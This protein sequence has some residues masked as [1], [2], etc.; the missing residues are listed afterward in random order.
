[1][2]RFRPGAQVVGWSKDALAEFV[3]ASE[4]ALGGP[5][6]RLAVRALGWWGVDVEEIAGVVGEALPGLAVEVAGDVDTGRF[7]F[8][9]VVGMGRGRGDADLGQELLHPPDRLE[10]GWW[11]LMASTTSSMP[12]IETQPAPELDVEGVA[13]DDV[14]PRGELSATTAA[15]AVDTQDDVATSPHEFVVGAG[16]D[17]C[18]CRTR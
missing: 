5:C 14:A 1:M 3:A 13:S 9:D 11:S 16:A 17:P 6:R 15:I 7:E 4:D 18:P 2:I 8:G 10:V 12:G